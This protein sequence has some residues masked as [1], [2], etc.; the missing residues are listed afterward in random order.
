MNKTLF[1]W[2][3]I[4]K[5]R[6]KRTGKTRYILGCI[7][8]AIGMM[9][10]MDFVQY[11]YSWHLDSL[12]MGLILLL[13]GLGLL[14]FTWRKVD[15]WNRYEAY[16]NNRGNTSISYIA[17]ALGETEDEVRA[18]L[19]QMINNHFFLG[20]ESNV[21][22]YIDGPRNLL[23]M[24]VDGK[25]LEPIEETVRRQNAQEAE[26][27]AKPEKK[28]EPAK[29]AGEKVLRDAMVSAD[30]R[31]VRKALSD[32]E[33]SITRISAKLAEDP[34][35][36]EKSSIR[37]LQR[38]YLP[39]TLE[40]V[41]K[42]QAEENSPETMEQ[43]GK[44]LTV[45][46]AAFGNIE[47]KITES[48]DMNTEADIETLQAMLAQDGLLAGQAGAKAGHAAAGAAPQTGQAAVQAVQK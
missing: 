32:L 20:P 44:A 39:M 42:Y 2:N 23:V 33:G 22:A 11:P 10:T 3:E 25:P 19:Q 13:I 45:C 21:E 17:K 18:T 8:A 30:D 47:R 36:K 35:L 41:R 24:T 5:I 48:D 26:A 34:Q 6:N 12:I 14:L 31:E 27:A 38:H 37:N 28:A 4:K 7:A 16:I 46:A 1:S 15:K 29:M 9:E 40:L 43:I